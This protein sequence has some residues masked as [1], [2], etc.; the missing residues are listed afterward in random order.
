MP[1]IRL[2]TETLKIQCHRLWRG[3]A[4]AGKTEN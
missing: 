1:T 3:S 4:V 2:E